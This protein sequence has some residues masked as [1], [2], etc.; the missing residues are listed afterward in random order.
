R[1]KS[2]GVQQGSTQCSNCAASK[3]ECTYDEPHK[4]RDISPS[5][6]DNLEKRL[7][8]AMVLLKKFYSDAEI[9]KALEDDES[10]MRLRFASEPSSLAQSSPAHS[11]PVYSGSP[12]GHNHTEPVCQSR[13]EGSDDEDSP[14]DISEYLKKMHVGDNVVRFWGKSSGVMLVK[15]AVSFKS[16]ISETGEEHWASSILAMRRPQFWHQLP[17]EDAPDP[18]AQ[19]RKYTFP[20]DDLLMT[21]VNHYFREINIF[22]PLLHRPTFVSDV[23][24]RRHYTD[25]DFAPVVLLVC[26]IGAR[27]SD[28]PRVLVEGT[29][30]RHS[31]ARAGL[32]QDQF[33]DADISYFADRPSLFRPPSLHDV[34]YCVLSVYFL[35]ATSAPQACWGVIG[36]GIRMAQ[37]AGAHRRRSAAT[38][39]KAEDELWKRAF[40]ILVYVDWMSAH[41]LGRP[42]ATQEM[43]FDLEPP[44]E[45]DDEYWDHPDP[46]KAWKQ[47]PGK[48]SLMSYFLAK[49]RLA[50]LIPKCLRTIYSLNN[51]LTCEQNHEIV[52]EL[53]SSFNAWA[54]TIPDHLRWNTEIK[55]ELFLRQSV[56]LYTT[57]YTLQILVHKPFIPRPRKPAS[58]AYPSLTICT[59]A[60]R[61]CIHMNDVY[62]RRM[63][64][65]LHVTFV[66]QVQC[67]IVLILSIWN[68]RLNGQAVEPSKETLYVQKA[69]AYLKAL[70]DRWHLPGRLWDVLYGLTVIGNVHNPTASTE[71]TQTKRRP[72]SDA[73]EGHRRSTSFSS[74]YTGTF[75]PPS[76]SA[77]SA[78]TSFPLPMHGWYP[79]DNVQ[80]GDAEGNGAGSSQN[81]IG[82]V[83]D[84]MAAMIDPSGFDF[85]AAFS[86]S[87]LDPSAMTQT[88]LTGPA[89]PNRQQAHW[90]VNPGAGIGI[91][92][93]TAGASSTGNW[94]PGTQELND[95][96]TS[97]W[98]DVLWQIPP[99]E[100]GQNGQNPL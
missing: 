5:S 1:K 15:S 49:L 12:S 82:A 26:A 98:S 10:M 74:Q 36:A 37:D 21:L 6:V 75:A 66:P 48:P 16:S 31:G 92:P 20:P 96:T 60:A 4:K 55:D 71:G 100:T 57:Y 91:S 46:A 69:M 62:M 39:S 58:L 33:T 35:Q 18:A 65:P 80:A 86:Y 93:S 61:S 56:D 90:P 88:P 7:E 27:F 84:M 63:G 28:D 23:V 30:S 77:T 83:D 11:S 41:S 50:V 85:N 79:Q 40:W 52:A 32:T 99:P 19:H 13:A 78:F 25:R 59:N 9:N 97:F 89:L 14:H 73:T 17:W 29:N 8:R 87:P 24:A 64:K 22:C 42:C 38:A 53:D 72:D 43:D 94:N 76:S 51:P 3:S 34:Q 68:S 54:N 81:N 2:D 67:G 45:C 70:E 47:P 95:W 44:I